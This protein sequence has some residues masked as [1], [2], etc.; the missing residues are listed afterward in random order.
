MMIR[1]EPTARGGGGTPVNEQVV[2][3]VGIG[4]NVKVP[5]IIFE[6]PN[7][8]QHNKWYDKGYYFP[9]KCS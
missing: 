9:G 4:S 6:S 7:V 3:G 2:E 1:A 8:V 5:P